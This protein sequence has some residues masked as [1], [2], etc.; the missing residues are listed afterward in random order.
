MGY[1]HVDKSIRTGFRTLAFGEYML[2]LS[3]VLLQDGQ[4]YYLCVLKLFLL[5]RVFI[6]ESRTTVTTLMM[7]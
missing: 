1:A 5:R 6:P 2:A 3:K 4:A 7:W